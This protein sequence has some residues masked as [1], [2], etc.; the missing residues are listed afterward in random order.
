MRYLEFTTQSLQR[1]GLHSNT[2]CR[3]L[4][5]WLLSPNNYLGH[6][7]YNFAPSTR[8]SRFLKH[9]LT[10]MFAWAKYWFLIRWE[11]RQ[12]L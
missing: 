1:Q 10:A 11:V 2:R 5:N 7:I 12:A 3:Q 4:L 6:H 9:L 8:T